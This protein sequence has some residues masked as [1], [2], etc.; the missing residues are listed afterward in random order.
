MHRYLIP[1]LFVGCGPCREEVK[2]A[3]T[4]DEPL[5]VADPVEDLPEDDLED[6]PEAEDSPEAATEPTAPAPEPEL[7]P[8]EQAIKE[9][10]RLNATGGIDEDGPES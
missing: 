5:E 7:S 8:E 1:L 9:A 4:L 10:E 3:P 2:P 6:L